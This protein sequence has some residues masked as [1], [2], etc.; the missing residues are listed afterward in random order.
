MRKTIFTLL[1]LLL[2]T[3]LQATD[4]GEKYVKAMKQALGMMDSAKTIQDYTN[5]ANRFE[6]IGNAEKKEWMP[7]YYAGL[8]Y[9]I[10]VYQ[11]KDVKKM[12]DILDRADQYLDTAL[13][14]KL[15]EEEKSEILV[16]KGMV[17][18]G[19]IMVDP[20]VRSMTYGPQSGQLYQR[21]VN[22]NPENPRALY[23]SAQSVMYTPKQFGGG[24]EKAI[25]MLEQ[26]LEL[27]DAWESPE[28]LF[29]DWGKEMAAGALDFAKS[30]KKAPWEE[31]AGEEG[32]QKGADKDTGNGEGHEGHD[33][34]DGSHD[35]HD[36]SE[37]GHSHEGGDTD[38]G[39]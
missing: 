14:M 6:R 11:E 36:H 37:E 16:I 13:D 22:L 23:M 17:C 24:R 15:K 2:G 1:I 20:Q 28:E 34:D 35:G 3:Q 9:A 32:G 25:P 18:G 8:C 30:G 10:M 19:R 4:G 7:Y 39:K 31:G 38:G 12:D 33:H 21:A 29:P 26:S 27:F 5:I